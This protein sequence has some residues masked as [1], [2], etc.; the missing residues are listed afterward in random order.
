MQMRSALSLVV[1]LVTLSVA[2]SSCGGGSSSSPTAPT[3]VT[4]V[5]PAAT[6]V[7]ISGAYSLAMRNS[8]SC[9]AFSASTPV[10]IIQIGSAIGITDNSSL[11]SGITAGGMTGI[12]TGSALS[13]RI[14]LIFNNGTTIWSARGQ[15]S[16]TA[17][18]G[19]VSGTVNGLLGAGFSGCNAANHSV[20]L[21]RQ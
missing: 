13:T 9:P 21:T 11:N 7:D 19:T 4:V 3:T 10:R 2:M 6:A 20:V 8:P 14:D 12:L 17:S 1:M 15:M 16:G 5:P 18:G